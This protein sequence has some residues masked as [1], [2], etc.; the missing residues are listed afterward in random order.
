[1]NTAQHKEVFSVC[2]FG[3]LRVFR[4]EAFFRCLARPTRKAAADLHE[5]QYG[6][7]T[8]LSSSTTLGMPNAH[9]ERLFNKS[10]QPS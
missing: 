1:M 6:N 8:D 5:F 3:A 10:K 4:G 2:R 9:P 7:S